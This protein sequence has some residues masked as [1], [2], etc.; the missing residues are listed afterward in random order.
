MTVVNFIIIFWVDKWLLLRFYKTPKNF[1]E[2]SILFTISEMKLAFIFHFII[3][4][5]AYSNDRILSKSETT[6]FL[7]T[8]V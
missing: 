1:N 3:G 4:I 7:K 8:V 6:G 2:K 5:I